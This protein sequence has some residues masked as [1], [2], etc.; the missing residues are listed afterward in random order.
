[1]ELKIDLKGTCISQIGPALM[2]IESGDPINVKKISKIQS[3]KPV[4][5]KLATLNKEIYNFSV[6][7]SENENFIYM[8]GGSG[9][10]GKYAFA[11]DLHSKKWS[12]LPRLNFSRS[13]HSSMILG[14]NLYTIGGRTNTNERVG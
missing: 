7:K 1:M 13:M 9:I 3:G 12:T 14:S 6:A 5:K 8:T 4:V 11:L 2:V 10:A